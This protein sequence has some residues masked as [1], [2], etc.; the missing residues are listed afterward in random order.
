MTKPVTKTRQAID[1]FAPFISPNKSAQ[2]SE[3]QSGPRPELPSIT[4]HLNTNIPSVRVQDQ[5]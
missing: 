5:C 3:N 1:F 2:V 4:A